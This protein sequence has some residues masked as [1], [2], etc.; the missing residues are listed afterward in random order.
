MLNRDARHALESPFTGDDGE[1]GW[2]T[3]Y[4]D[5]LTLLITLFVLLLALTP[6]G[7]G[8]EA[9]DEGHGLTPL[10]SGLLPRDSGL[11]PAMAALDI[12]GVSV[13]QGREGVTLRIDD[14]LLFDSGAAEL[15]AQG[16]GVLE[17][18]SEVI[19]TF[20]G[21]VSVEGHTDNVPISTAAF[22]SNWEL[23][24]GRAIAVVRHLEQEGVARQRLRAVGYADTRPLAENDTL[25]GRAAN[26][27]VEF[28]LRTLAPE[29]A[30]L[31]L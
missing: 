7:S 12:Q 5:V 1:E 22:A 21:E 10:S 17:R 16:E 11:S 3:S 29:S 15:T 23:S 20:E 18:L 31:T 26:R 28:V 13:S 6:A 9:T 14:S 24:T 4:L 19:D 8:G 25:E 30:A 2:L 27:R